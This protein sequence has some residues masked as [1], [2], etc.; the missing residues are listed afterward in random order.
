MLRFTNPELLLLLP[1]AG[2][3]L[4][5]WARRKRP[6]LRYSD[7]SL[8]DGLP[9]G[10]ARFAKGLSITWRALSLFAILFAAAGPSVPD[11]KTRLSA[12]GVTVVVALDISGSMGEEDFTWMANEKP[13]S[14][15]VTAKRALR[16]F[17]VGGD[18]LDGK[19]FLGRPVDS[20]GLVSFAA[21]PDASCPLTLNHSVFLAVLDSLS[22]KVG[23]DAGTNI[24]DAIAESLIRLE[25][26]GA[27]RKVLI[28]VS[29]GEHNI[30]LDRADPPL[31]PRQAAQLAVDL[32][33]PIYSIDC[34]G[35][36]T[37]DAESLARRADGRTVLKTV[38][39]MTDG[40]SFIANDGEQLRAACLE[41]DRL[42]RKPV[43]SFSYRREWDL[44]PWFVVVGLIALVVGL[45]F[46]KVFWRAI[47]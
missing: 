9:R 6:G 13:I 29:D 19:R 15:L 43:E 2:L 28:L 14:R 30:A 16:L 23:P 41:I 31:K 44:S 34:G 20:L 10:R 17:A 5:W 38:A 33:I 39:E 40:K 32:K 3:F 26:A 36:G 42:E 37:G 21:W 45:L 18:G 22:P 12:E 8:V 35:E 1:L 27:S 4:I 11:L 46:E 7:V 25:G 24:G 47:P